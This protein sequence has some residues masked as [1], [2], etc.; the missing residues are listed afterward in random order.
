MLGGVGEQGGGRPALCRGRVVGTRQG[1]GAGGRGALRHISTRPAAGGLEG[2]RLDLPAFQV[3]GCG[4]GRL[5]A[6]DKWIALQ[7]LTSQPERLRGL[8]G[9]AWVLAFCRRRGGCGLVWVQIWASLAGEAGV[10]AP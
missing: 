3:V 10:V 2:L 1:P 8:P 6:E 9:G 7:R 5:P 4:R